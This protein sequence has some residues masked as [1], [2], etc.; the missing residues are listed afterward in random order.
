MTF[1]ISEEQQQDHH[2]HHHDKLRAIDPDHDQI[3]CMCCCTD[4]GEG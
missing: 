3:S 2:H 1:E 4:C